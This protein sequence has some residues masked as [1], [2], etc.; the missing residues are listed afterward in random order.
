MPGCCCWHGTRHFQSWHPVGLWWDSCLTLSKLTACFHSAVDFVISPLR[1]QCQPGQVCQ[2]TRADN[3]EWDLYLVCGFSKFWWVCCHSTSGMTREIH[4]IHTD[5]FR[6][7]SAVQNP[8][9]MCFQK[10]LPPLCNTKPRLCIS[11]DHQ[12]W[13]RHTLFLPKLLLS[14]KLSTD[15]EKT[16]VGPAGT[17][18]PGMSVDSQHNPSQ[19]HLKANTTM[20][21]SPAV[22]GAQT[23]PQWPRGSFAMSCPGSHHHCTIRADLSKAQHCPASQDILAEPRISPFPWAAPHDLNVSLA[24]ILDSQDF[25][26][27][28]NLT[29][30]RASMPPMPGTKQTETQI[31]EWDTGL[32]SASETDKRL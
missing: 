7:P 24:T 21:P 29:I 14:P 11:S 4:A 28:E 15:G 1:D 8:S 3:A 27:F 25:S 20:S 31:R 5:F 2:S 9:L 6:K 32:L 23:G 30:F 12:D 19:G 16:T 13:T 26:I 22:C 17:P 18:A 10:H